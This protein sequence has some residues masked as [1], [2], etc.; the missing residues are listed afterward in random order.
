MKRMELQA[1]REAGAT[2]LSIGVGALEEA[3]RAAAAFPTVLLVADENVGVTP[4]F[5]RIEAAC[6][7]AGGPEPLRFMLPVGEE[8]K[9]LEFAEGLCRQWLQVGAGRDAVVLAV[10][11]GVLTDLAGFSASIFLRGVPW[12][13][14]PT[15]VLGMADASIGGK[16]GVN[17]DEGKNLVG[18]F[19][20]PVSIHA[21]PETVTT[22]G[23]DV[24]CEG[25]AEVIKAGVI[26]DLA[27][28]ERLEA[29]AEAVRAR[30]AVVLAAL[31]AASI[32]VKASIVSADTREAGPRE[33]LNFGHTLAHALETASAHELSHGEA[34]AIGMVAEA[35]LGA[36]LGRFGE[37]LPQRIAACCAGLNLSTALPE[38]LEDETLAAALS[39]DKKRRS[40]R[41]RIAL[42][43]ALGAYDPTE[44]CVEFEASFLLAAARG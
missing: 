23:D 41:L 20:H 8:T 3:G 13:A 26:A 28:F 27:L 12:I 35:K 10:G 42:P 44:P 15:T 17:L 25:W 43:T 37:E 2:A 4:W 7:E 5:A 14:V 24:Y 40:G 18:S 31:L 39:L 6:L 32:E 21:D 34:V 1:P 30:D 11:G 16:T 33:I 38:G 9:S 36:Q 29:E 19:W 22:L